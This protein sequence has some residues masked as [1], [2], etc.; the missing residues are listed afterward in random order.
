MMEK[1]STTTVKTKVPG[2]VITSSPY[3]LT[4]HKTTLQPFPA[5]LVPS[6]PTTAVN[7]GSS[8]ISPTL[9][10][11]DVDE[12][13]SNPCPP[14][15][16]CI[17][18]QGS[19]QCICSLGYQMAKGK[20]NLVRTFVG[21]F[22]LMFNTTG[23]TYS[24]LHQIEGVIINLLNESLSTFPGYYTSTV[25]AS[26]QKGV[27]QISI[28]STF[29]MASNITFSEVI[30]TVRSRIRACKAPTL[31]CQ[32]I[33]NLTQLYRVGGLCKHKDPECDKGTSVCVD[34]DGIAVCQCKP[35]YFKYNKLDH[36]CR[37]CEDGYKLENDTCVSCP[38]GLGGF[39]CRNPYQ[40][41]TIVIAAAGGGLLLI[42][43]I[44]LIVT[45]C[46][47]NKND[48]SKLIFK[49]GDFQMSPYAEYPKNPRVQDWSRETIE[50]QENGSTKNLLQMTDVYYMPANLRNPELERN[51]IYPP[52]TGLPGSR[53]SCIYPGQ[54][55]PSFISDDSRRR[56]YF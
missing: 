46:Q 19:F 13:L 43:G 18:V 11:K 45:C 56:D 33:S 9:Y 23:G 2:I 55:N 26:R 34:L 32:F 44:A 30:G 4:S 3:T 7:L 35:G 31:L 28:L 5:S 8:K 51:G 10:G 24:E 29:S 47:K 53:H 16:T 25:K 22:P 49:S 40:L 12:C 39:N 50:M 52:Y 41:I 15:A 37:A 27:V 14:M 38:F 20:C 6:R 48:I 54:Y 21:H 1:S 36:S 42:M 17:N